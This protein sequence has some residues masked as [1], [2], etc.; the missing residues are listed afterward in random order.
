M[1]TMMRP[2]LPL[3]P[4]VLRFVAPCALHRELCFQHRE[5]WISL[6]ARISRPP[7]ADFR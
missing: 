5:T 3:W 6:C 4:P 2:L 1:R 7:R